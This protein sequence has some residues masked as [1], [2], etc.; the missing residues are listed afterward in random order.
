M[1]LEESATGGYV[2]N[3]GPTTK[4]DAEVLGRHEVDVASRSNAIQVQHERAEDVVVVLW[5]LLQ[6]RAQRLVFVRAVLYACECQR[7][8]TMGASAYQQRRQSSRAACASR[9]GSAI[10]A[11]TS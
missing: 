9:V 2:R 5:Q 6:E 11:S 7:R 1:W 3:W 10:A 8:N 4:D